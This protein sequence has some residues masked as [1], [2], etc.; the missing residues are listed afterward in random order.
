MSP[1]ITIVGTKTAS[2]TRVVATTAPPT[3]YMVL[4]AASFGG[5]PSSSMIRIVFSVTM[6][7]SSTTMPMARIRPNRLR[8]LIENPAANRTA[9]VPI[10]DTG[11]AT[12]GTS[13]G[14]QSC[15]KMNTTS[16]TRMT[17]MSSVVI[18]SLIDCVMYRVE[19]YGTAHARPSGNRSSSVANAALTPLATSTAFAPGS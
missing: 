14:R 15:R 9:N 10:S 6:I 17:A 8:L 5:R 16:T 12:V 13:V 2:S 1:G 11:M 3:S 19:S 7:E 4:L 18:T